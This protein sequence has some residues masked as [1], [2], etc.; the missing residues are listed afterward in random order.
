[1]HAITTLACALFL[2]ACGS[3]P[4]DTGVV[5]VVLPAE[6][7]ELDPRHVSDSYGLKL[8]RLLF[9][10]LVRIDPTTL[11]PVPD[12]AERVDIVSPTE[13]RVTL[14]E[15]LRFS[16]GSALDADD[17]VA[18]FESVLD[19]AT[20]SRYR[21]SYARI[22]SIR[23]QDARTVV[24]TLD[25]PHAP[26]FT[27]LELPI[28][29]AE[30][31][32]H[33][34]G[35]GRSA[36]FSGS[37]AYR[38]ASRTSGA[39]ELVRNPNWHR[40][41]SH[42]ERLRFLVVRDDNT[43]ALRLLGGAGDYALNAVPPMLTPLFKQPEFRV[44]RAVGIG[45][46]YMGLNLRSEA[47]RDP[48]VREALA[49]GLDRAAL[50]AGKF[51]GRAQLA[52]GLLPP[53]HW[54]ADA[55]ARPL[56]FDPNRARALLREAGVT[57]PPRLV[58]RTS[59]DRFRQSI[60]NAVATMLRDVGF[61]VEVRPTELATLLG[62]LGAGRFDLTILQI[63]ELVEP[64]TLHS[65][66]ASE[67]IPDPPRR[68]GSNRWRFSDPRVDAALER[69]RVSTDR[70]VRAEAYRTVERL[71]REALPVIPLW[72]EDVISVTSRRLGTLPVPRDAR[73]HSLE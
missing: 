25:A 72:H 58:L 11:E 42:F 56:P 4:A 12:L 9:A 71:L 64:H 43:R 27:D 1:M 38:I 60:A 70:E 46:T 19:P 23:R 67:R 24:F 16:D 66:F 39:I 7:S 2:V 5:T 22:R 30:D 53:G 29:R 63:P 13:Y 59:S 6:P 50:I 49:L 36:S 41:R 69:G 45:T 34:L 33:H 28:L 17:V 32:A 8:S 20:Q 26:F 47:L 21:A 14:R 37:G 40:G 48:R 62:D 15:N 51:Q 35:G 54:A 44:D 61:D 73:F 65:F 52:Q 10:S 55:E 57:S 68:E 31:R 3:A 18:T